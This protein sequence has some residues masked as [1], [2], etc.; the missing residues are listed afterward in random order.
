MEGNEACTRMV[1]PQRDYFTV[2]EMA[3]I[4]AVLLHDDPLRAYR[5]ASAIVT[6]RD[7]HGPIHRLIWNAIS[8][9]AAEGIAPDETNLK[10]RLTERGQFTKVGGDAYLFQITGEC[11][12]ALRAADYANVVRQASI[13]RNMDKLSRETQEI[14]DDAMLPLDDRMAKVRAVFREFNE[15]STVAECLPVDVAIDEMVA[16]TTTITVKEGQDLSELQFSNP[17]VSTGSPLDQF[18]TGYR[19]Q[20]LNVIAARPGVGKTSFAISTS[21]R[22]LDNGS[23]IALFT[24]EMS[25]Q[26]YLMR[27]VSQIASVPASKFDTQQLTREDHEQV[28]LAFDDMRRNWC[29]R[30]YDGS[31]PSADKLLSMIESEVERGVD[32]IFIDHVGIVEGGGRSRYESQTAV[33]DAC[34]AA[35]QRCHVPIVALIQFNRT[36]TAQRIGPRGEEKKARPPGIADIR[37]SGKWEENADLIV[38]LHRPAQAERDTDIQLDNYYRDNPHA[39]DPMMLR[40][41]KNR[42]G[43][44]CTAECGFHGP[45]Q[46]IVDHLGEDYL[47]RKAGIIE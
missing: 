35:K 7:F 3:T 11:E 42:H 37:D 17:T 28:T 24:F 5:K 26:Q 47:R 46:A 12:T 31:A 32:Y 9:L 41:V 6:V 45:M 39:L 36:S 15:T 30:I 33:A 10:S 13:K 16:T 19:E 34:L 38:A 44:L 21:R 25:R 22:L 40:V 43:Q 20:S 23:R 29:L 8:S 2:A 1:N 18:I 4:G 27:F 14:A